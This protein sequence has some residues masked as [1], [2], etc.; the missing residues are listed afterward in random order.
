MA[1]FPGFGGG[2]GKL[3]KSA[4]GTRLNTTYLEIMIPSCPLT[5]RQICFARF[6][7]RQV[8][9]FSE[10]LVDLA[11]SSRDLVLACTFCFPITEHVMVPQRTEDCFFPTS[12][13][14]RASTC[15]CMHNKWKDKR[16]IPWRASRG[17]N[18][19]NKTHKLLKKVYCGIPWKVTHTREWHARG[20]AIATEG[21]KNCSYLYSRLRDGNGCAART[22][23]P[24]CLMPSK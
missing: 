15:K 6:F 19:E 3:G 18:W 20:E 22:M 12:S 2:A 5:A 8:N 10:A 23:E 7:C 17:L 16:Q 21:E 11:S 14:S 13:Y 9:G 24:E 1:L 4:L